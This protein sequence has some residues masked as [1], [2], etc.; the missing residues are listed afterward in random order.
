M[1]GT[2]E[3]PAAELKVGAAE[4]RAPRRTPR[5]GQHFDLGLLTILPSPSEGATQR[6]EEKPLDSLSFYVILK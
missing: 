4:A 2:K 1:K 6:A 5:L 3:N